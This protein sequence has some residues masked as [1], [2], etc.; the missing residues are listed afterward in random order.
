MTITIG[1][2][3]TAGAEL[4]YLRCRWCGTAM[5]HT[6]LF[7]PVCGSTEADE[8]TSTGL[9]NIRRIMRVIRPEHREDEI[10]Q[11]CTVDLEEGFT[12]MATV[13]PQQMGAVPEGTR[14]RLRSI[15]GGHPALEF[16][17]R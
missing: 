4:H 14:V 11:I 10:R 1:E 6:R 12:V 16:T 17:P 8:K 15:G 2:V 9:G 5:E 3:S 7:C 13:R